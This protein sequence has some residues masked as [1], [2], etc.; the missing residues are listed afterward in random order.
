MAQK[1]YSPR[2][3]ARSEV[4]IKKSRRR[5]LFG[6]GLALTLLLALAIPVGMSA[7][8][9]PNAVVPAAT[10]PASTDPVA[11][12]EP[13]LSPD[14]EAAQGVA[15]S[16]LNQVATALVEKYGEEVRESIQYFADMNY[17]DDEGNPA[18]IAIA[19]LQG[20]PADFDYE[21]TIA[22]FKESLPNLGASW[23]SEENT[24]PG[25]EDIELI[26]DLIMYATDPAETD[27]VSAIR[28]TYVKEAG[29]DTLTATVTATVYPAEDA[30]A[31]PTPAPTSV[32]TE[33]PSE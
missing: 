10:E 19:T 25:T 2:T 23:K 8:S 9:D 6:R 1:S 17:A 22:S 7:F 16:T 21:S 31:D 5:Q 3:E 28:V 11:T 20:I 15:T 32:P 26:H 18:N 24:T 33:T 13:T 14:E 29:A 4:F 27:P 12:P 30:T